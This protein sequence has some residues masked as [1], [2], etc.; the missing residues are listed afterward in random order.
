MI[1]VLWEWVVFQLICFLDWIIYNKDTR[2]KILQ[3]PI[4]AHASYRSGVGL[5]YSPPPPYDK[6][7]YYCRTPPKWKASTI[8]LS[9]DKGDFQ[10]LLQ[11]FKWRAGLYIQ[12]D[13]LPGLMT[14]GFV[15]SE[16][17]VIAEEGIVLKGADFHYQTHSLHRASRLT[18]CRIYRLSSQRGTYVQWTGSLTV[19][20]QTEEELYRFT[21]SSLSKEQVYFMTAKRTTG[22]S[23]AQEVYRWAA[24]SPEKAFNALY[25]DMPMEGWWPWPKKAKSAKVTPNVEEV[26]GF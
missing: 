1:M 4:F 13:D 16:T 17:N 18:C 24:N 14:Q 7:D 11:G 6:P 3:G 19:A 15:W 20:F 5:T 12:T 21:V 22:P 23:S 9:R 10:N 26:E 25:D 8:L 2:P